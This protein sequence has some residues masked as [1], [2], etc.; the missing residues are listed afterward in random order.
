MAAAAW[1][2]AWMTKH[3]GD[4]IT[5]NIYSNIDSNTATSTS[6]CSF[7]TLCVLAE[8]FPLIHLSTMFSPQR[9]RFYLPP[10]PSLTSMFIPVWI[11]HGAEAAAG[12]LTVALV[13]T[14]SLQQRCCGFHDL[15]MLLVLCCRT[16]EADST[17]LAATLNFKHQKD[18]IKTLLCDRNLKLLEMENLRYLRFRRRMKVFAHRGGASTL[19]PPSFS[20]SSRERLWSQSEGVLFHRKPA[21]QHLQLK[22]GKTHTRGLLTKLMHLRV[23]EK[24]SSFHF[25]LQQTL[26]EC[27]DAHLP[28]V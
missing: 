4:V 3:G 1:A 12:K 7:W 5:S 10:C 25:R 16:K 20:C 14:V 6:S 18:Q 13:W 22:E 9:R 27:V 21:F 19:P 17:V 24:I 15:I 11:S 23:G 2:V 28:T 26:I 8:I